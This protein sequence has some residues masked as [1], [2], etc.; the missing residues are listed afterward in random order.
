MKGNALKK[1]TLEEV[2]N[3]C[4]E[5]GNSVNAQAFL[6]HYDSNGWKVGKNP[7]RD[8]KA[9]VRT[10]ERNE[11]G[12]AKHSGRKKW[13]TWAEAGIGTEPAPVSEI[14]QNNETIPGDI[15]DLFGN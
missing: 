12:T 15:L 1:P 9:T 2:Q 14:K 5:R 3:Y 7:M 13:R 6:D 4:Q 11:Y 10:W 8:W